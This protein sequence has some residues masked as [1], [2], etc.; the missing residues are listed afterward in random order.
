MATRNYTAEA[1]EQIKKTIEEIDNTDVHPVKDFFSDLFRRLGQFLE[2]F[3]VDQYKEDMQKWYDIVLDSHNSTINEVY[4]IFEEVGKVDEEYQKTMD[5]AVSSVTNFRS[6]LNCLRDVISG[7]TS[8]AG[9]GF[10]RGGYLSRSGRR[11][12]GKSL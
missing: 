1:Y 4:N 8:L 7:K 5:G 12:S 11:K 10:R 9:G 2:L 6:T 3:T